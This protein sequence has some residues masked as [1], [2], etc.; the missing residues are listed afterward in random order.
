M[1]WTAIKTFVGGLPT[2]VIPAVAG[3]IALFAVVFGIYHAGE[4]SA[5]ATAAESLA[6][7]NAKIAKQEHD[8]ALLAQKQ[9]AEATEEKLKI[10]ADK[11]ALKNA[12]ENEARGNASPGCRRAVAG[13]LRNSP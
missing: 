7:D 6:A 9:F 12:I 11:D 1:I 2:W 3:A 13:I 8:A 5:R 4:A 10:Q